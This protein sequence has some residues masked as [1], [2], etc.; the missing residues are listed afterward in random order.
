VATIV[1]PLKA[2]HSRWHP[3][4]RGNGVTQTPG[5]ADSADRKRRKQAERLAQETQ[6]A[7]RLGI[8]VPELRVKLWL[9]YQ[10][11]AKE[12]SQRPLT[13]VYHPDHGWL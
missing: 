10:T 13:Y 7:Q 1:I 8:S 9:A 4:K 11:T 3:G 5:Q 2:K 12:S 6:E